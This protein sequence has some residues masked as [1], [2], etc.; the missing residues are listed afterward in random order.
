MTDTYDFI[1]Y[2][3]RYDRRYE[4][5]QIFRKGHFKQSNGLIVPIKFADY[6]DGISSTIEYGHC[7]GYAALE[8]RDDGVVAKCKFPDGPGVKF[9]KRLLIDRGEYVLIFS[10]NSFDSLDRT[11]TPGAITAVLITMKWCAYKCE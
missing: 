8:E 4:N 9:I 11:I 1:D 10:S 7:Y 5:G 3:V 2:I 6:S